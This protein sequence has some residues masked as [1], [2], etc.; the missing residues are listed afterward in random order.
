MDKS[1]MQKAIVLATIFWLAGCGANKYVKTTD[2]LCVTTATKTEAG[3]TVEKVLS[4]MRFKIEKSD[5]EAGL[6]RTHPLPGAQ[7]FEFWRS[8]SIGAA[9]NAEADLQSIRRTVEINITPQ[10]QQVCINCKATTQRL[11]MPQGV[12]SEEQGYGS[13]V[14]TRRSVQKLPSAGQQKANFKWIDLGR[15]SQL[16][17]EIIKRIESRLTADKKQL[18]TAKKDQGK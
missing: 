5:I 13:L 6:I 1:I 4:E 16:E 7:S 14:D 17:T 2:R 15:D 12:S 9:N 18:T 11:S 3:T 8:D 10:E